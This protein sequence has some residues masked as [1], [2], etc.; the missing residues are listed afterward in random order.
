MENIPT[1]PTQIPPTPS[2]DPDSIPTPTITEV[3]S[4]ALTLPDQADSVVPPP[5]SQSPISLQRDLAAGGSTPN[6]L[7]TTPSLQPTQATGQP[8]SPPP[9]ND[10]LADY[11]KNMN[12]DTAPSTPSSEIPP[13]SLPPSSQLPPPNSQPAPPPPDPNK[14]DS[15]AD[16]KI[17]KLKENPIVAEQKRAHRNTIIKWVVVIIN[18]LLMGGLMYYYFFLSNPSSQKIPNSTANTAK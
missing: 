2:V 5:S 3:N 17:K 1:I 13:D 11:F 15:A 18:F 14:P 16:K 12:N 8:V 9:E 6:S 4:G 10:P 7:P